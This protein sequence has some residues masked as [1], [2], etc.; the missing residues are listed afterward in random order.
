MFSLSMATQLLI[1]SMI[2]IF[3]PFSYIFAQLLLLHPT[4]IRWKGHI[5]GLRGDVRLSWFWFRSWMYIGNYR[6]FLGASSV[7]RAI[8]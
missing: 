4:E 8:S 5:A 7:S 2:P 3:L 1:D 6:Y